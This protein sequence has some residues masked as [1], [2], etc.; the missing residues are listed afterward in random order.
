V[1]RH[2]RSSAG[3]TKCTPCRLLTRWVAP[4]ACCAVL[5]CAVLCCAVVWCGVLCC[6]ERGV[7]TSG[8]QRT[9]APTRDVYVERSLEN[10][11][12]FAGFGR[13]TDS[14]C[15]CYLDPK[16]LPVDA[17]KVGVRQRGFRVAPACAVL[18]WV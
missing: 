3:H 11:R 12:N 18:R 13:S 6:A 4:C 14:Y 2:W 15:D 1:A 17:I 9:E 5:C 7:D 8:V 10:D 16:Q